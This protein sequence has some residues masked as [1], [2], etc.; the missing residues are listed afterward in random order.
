MFVPSVEIFL[1]ATPISRA[2]E[3]LPLNC[4]GLAASRAG[5]TNGNENDNR[6]QNG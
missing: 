6:R 2:G 5:R 1:V 4:S 3:D